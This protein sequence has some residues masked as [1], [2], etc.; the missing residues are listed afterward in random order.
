[1]KLK[2]LNIVF[3][4][5]VIIFSEINCAPKHPT[6]EVENW[7]SHPQIIEIRELVQNT[8]ENVNQYARIGVEC[9]E[10]TDFYYLLDKKSVIRYYNLQQ[11]GEDFGEIAEAY[12]DAEGELRFYYRLDSG[13]TPDRT[14]TWKQM[15]LRIY[16]DSSGDKIWEIENEKDKPGEKK[17]NQMPIFFSEDMNHKNIPLLLKDYGCDELSENS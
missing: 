6:I 17:F 3:I 13:Y 2:T 1:M 7:N 8:Q 9:P 12:F 15:E 10:K 11:V 16:Y 5:A 4:F 14:N